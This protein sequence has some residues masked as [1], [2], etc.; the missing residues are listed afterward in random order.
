MKYL[1]IL[2]I[3]PFLAACTRNYP[4]TPN[5]GYTD[6]W[7][8]YHDADTDFE[9]HFVEDGTMAHS[10]E[11]DTTPGND[12]WYEKNGRIYFSMND[13]YANYEGIVVDSGWVAGTAKN[14]KGLKWEW[15]M[16]EQKQ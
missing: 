16:R 11:G 13:G 15:Q 8:S 12:R 4:V 6:T 9:I 10:N 7:W 5:S 14:K 2:L 1:F 3:L